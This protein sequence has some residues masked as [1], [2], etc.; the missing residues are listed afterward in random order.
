MKVCHNYVYM[1][2]VNVYMTYVLKYKHI[3]PDVG[4]CSGLFRYI[5]QGE[6]WQSGY[7]ESADRR[8]NKGHFANTE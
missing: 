5:K 6:T 4:D 1:T 8:Y 2:Y 3:T 7:V